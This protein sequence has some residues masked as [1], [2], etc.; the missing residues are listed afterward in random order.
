[1]D[2]E[3]GEPSIFRGALAGYAIASAIGS[4]IVIWLS[5]DSGQAT[6]AGGTK[7][8]MWVGVL[9]ALLGYEI[10]V[11]RRQARGISSPYD[12]WSKFLGSW[13]CSLIGMIVIAG[14]FGIAFSI[15][16]V[17]DA[18]AGKAG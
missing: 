16:I 7:L 15:A 4:M 8:L 18:I 5:I 10:T 3:E 11:K 13:M 2:N 6:V 1:M 17:Y 14:S 9:G 12:E